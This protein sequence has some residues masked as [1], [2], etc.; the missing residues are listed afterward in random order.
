MFLMRHNAWELEKTFTL[1]KSKRPWICPNPGF[2]NQLVRFE[3]NIRPQIELKKEESV[4][5]KFIEEDQKSVKTNRSGVTS[6][7]GRSSMKVADKGAMMTASRAFST[8]KTDMRQ[9]KANQMRMSGMKEPVRDQPLV[10][11][12]MQ[13]TGFKEP[14]IVSHKY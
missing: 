14:K 6:V 12:L 4:V 11:N 8:Q 9:S 7:F 2:C 10:R 5:R 1:V 13:S 3:K